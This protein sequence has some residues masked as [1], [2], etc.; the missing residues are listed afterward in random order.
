MFNNDCTFLIFCFLVSYA[1][2]GKLPLLVLWC[3]MAWFKATYGISEGFEPYS[4]VLPYLDLF[5][6]WLTM[7]TSTYDQIPIKLKLLIFCHIK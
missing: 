5:A 7:K 1:I 2:C 6:V 3:C 4:S